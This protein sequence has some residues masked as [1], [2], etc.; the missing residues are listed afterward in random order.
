[1]KKIIGVLF[2]I[3]VV[4]ISAGCYKSDQQKAYEITKKF[5]ELIKT[6]NYKNAYKLYAKKINREDE[7]IKDFG[8]IDY[9]YQHFE[10]HMKKISNAFKHKI[11]KIQV[12]KYEEWQLA[13]IFTENK[14]ISIAVVFSDKYDTLKI[15]HVGIINHFVSEDAPK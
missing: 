3:S 13:S 5:H 15:I 10:K 4:L 2:I 9:N 6:K 11:E 14:Q 8:V 12:N 1:M 7:K